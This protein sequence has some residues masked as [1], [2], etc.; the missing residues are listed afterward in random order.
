M[1]R[2]N[3]NSNHITNGWPDKNGNSGNGEAVAVSPVQPPVKSL[4]EEYFTNGNGTATLLPNG[5]ATKNNQINNNNN[6]LLQKNKNHENGAPPTAATV[7]NVKLNGNGIAY[8]SSPPPAAAA[9]AAVKTAQEPITN[10]YQH[11]N[12]RSYPYTD[13]PTLL[14]N[15]NGG[16]VAAAAAP[17][18]TENVDHQQEPA[19]EDQLIVRNNNH[20]NLKNNKNHHN[21]NN[22]NN[23]HNNKSATNPAAATTTTNGGQQQHHL[24]GNLR[25]MN[26]KVNGGCLA[27]NGTTQTAKQA[28]GNGTAAASVAV[29]VDKECDESEPLTGHHVGDTKTPTATLL[30]LAKDGIKRRRLD[31][32][33]DEESGNEGA[34]LRKEQQAGNGGGAGVGAGGVGYS[35]DGEDENDEDRICGI[36]SCR[37]K[38]ATKLAS[39]KV[40]M[41]VFLLAWVLQGMYSTY[42]VSVITTIEKLFQIQSKVTGVLL[43]VTEIGQISTALFLTYYAGRGHRPRWIACGE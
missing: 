9:P 20:L 37:P 38:W 35:D 33:E 7:T 36:G 14:A 23:S 40:F 43:S 21:N 13:E 30:L 34:R 4:R 26:G 12:G 41:V 31:E 29:P 28:N 25:L 19:E 10:N 24:Q 6:S 22:I 15:G 2:T 16:A 11:A 1:L 42:F 5:D 8:P 39:T 27:T 18:T 17:V 3:N 32:S